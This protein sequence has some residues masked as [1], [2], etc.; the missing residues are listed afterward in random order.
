MSFNDI[1]KSENNTEKDKEYI[2]EK[3]STTNINELDNIK[4]IKE[5][6]S[7]EYIIEGNISLENSF[8]IEDIENLDKEKEYQESL[9]N[10]YE[11]NNLN[12]KSSSEYINKDEYY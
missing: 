5:D 7:S 4:I 1:I 2:Y 3:K 11:E 8:S 6:S 10:Q 12:Y 9:Y